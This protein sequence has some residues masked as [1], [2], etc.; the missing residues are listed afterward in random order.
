MVDKLATKNYASLNREGIQK[1]SWSQMKNSK[2]L[3]HTIFVTSEIFTFFYPKFFKESKNGQFWNVQFSL[4]RINVE[5]K[6]KHR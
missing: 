4:G 6:Q 2:I 3:N 5:K 1:S